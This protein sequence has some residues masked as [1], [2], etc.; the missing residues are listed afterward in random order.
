MTVVVNS[1]DDF[2][3]VNF[4][5]VSYG[6][7]PAR[8]GGQA[9]QALMAG[10]QHGPAVGSPGQ[11]H[12]P[13]PWPPAPGPGFGGGP[14]RGPLLGFVSAPGPAWDGPARTPHVP[15]TSTPV[16]SRVM[17]ASFLGMR[18]WLNGAAVG[19]EQGIRLFLAQF[20]RS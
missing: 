17:M 16:M 18:R 2:T 4:W 3:L 1:R 20:P 5:R 14:A 7:E 11:D 19:L 8:L 10:A 12:A 13:R 15:R 6:G 9:R